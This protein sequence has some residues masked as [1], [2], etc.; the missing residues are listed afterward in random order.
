MLTVVSWP[1]M[2]S[3][4]AVFSTSTRDMRP[5]GPSSFTS[6]EIRSSVG[7]R[8]FSSASAERYSVSCAV[9]SPARSRLAAASSGPVASA[10]AMMSSLQAWKRGSSSRGTPSTSQIIVTGKG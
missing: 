6:P 10:V 3:M 4:I 2:S 1:P 7:L 8:A 9:A 5:P